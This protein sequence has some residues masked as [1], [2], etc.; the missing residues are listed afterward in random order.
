MPRKIM[1]RLLGVIRKRN[2]LRL[3]KRI[4]QLDLDN[5]ARARELFAR[6]VALPE[7]KKIWGDRLFAVL[8]VGSS[9]VGIRAAKSASD[10]DI[11]AVVTKQEYIQ[12]M[13]LL[14]QSRL[15]IEKKA[16]LHGVPF[17]FD[18]L[19]REVGKEID[20]ATIDKISIKNHFYPVG[21]PFQV[22]W[23][24]KY[25]DTTNQFLGK[26]RIEEMRKDYLRKKDK[27]Y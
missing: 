5:P 17:K 13:N 12:S 22:I 1:R 24:I 18:I 3:G 8:L 15:L 23:G 9:Q 4:R 27:L 26:E 6:K 2:P 11:V 10:C 20:R 21:S 19:A 7:L 16:K 25:R 14:K